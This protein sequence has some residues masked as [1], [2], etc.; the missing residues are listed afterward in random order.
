[1]SDTVLL[2]DASLDQINSLLSKHGKRVC[3]SKE[4]K[5]A[6]L[7]II[8]TNSL[9]ASVG[10]VLS[11]N[12]QQLTVSDCKQIGAPQWLIKL[13][14]SR[15]HEED[16]ERLLNV[17][18]NKIE[19]LKILPVE[20]MRDAG[21]S[22]EA[23][24]TI[25]RLTKSGELQNSKTTI[26][27]L[28]SVPSTSRESSDANSTLVQTNGEI[29]IPVNLSENRNSSRQFSDE[30]VDSVVSFMMNKI[31]NQQTQETVSTAN[32]QR[33][34]RTIVTLLLQILAGK[35]PFFRLIQSAS[36]IWNLL[37]QTANSQR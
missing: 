12:V 30:I 32:L 7:P 17:G 22:I 1:M 15:V 24:R 34:V 33:Y 31:N 23:R 37:N 19:H 29:D 27:E 14:R 25:A 20:V 16:I 4:L 2:P 6:W 13:R 36:S 21:L 28:S 3:G 11:F 8:L 9:R 35:L 26:I 18:V 10:E 5:A